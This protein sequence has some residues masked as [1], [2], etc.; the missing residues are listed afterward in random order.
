MENYEIFQTL[1]THF[2]SDKA[3]M[4]MENKVEKIGLE[5]T[6]NFYFNKFKKKF[7]KEYHEELKNEIQIQVDSMLGLY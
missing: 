6:C 3:T 4:E 1:E 7:D 5:K 2:E